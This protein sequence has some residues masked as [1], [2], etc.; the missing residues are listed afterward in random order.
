MRLL[1]L[2]A[3]SI[4]I[5]GCNHEVDIVSGRDKDQYN[6]IDY[7][8][9]LKISIDNDVILLHGD[10]N[11][12]TIKSIWFAVQDCTRLTSNTAPY[13]AVVNEIQDYNGLYY[14]HDNVIEVEYMLVYSRTIRHEMIHYL[15]DVNGYVVN[16]HESSLFDKC[17]PF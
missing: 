2:L 14:R 5:L 4:F 15:L 9:E 11:L 13:I 3:I 10:I 12:Q 1:I 17:S 8:T 7:E 16:N 6:L